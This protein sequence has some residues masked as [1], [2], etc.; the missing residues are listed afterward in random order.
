MTTNKNLI[1]ILRAAAML[2]I[3]SIQLTQY[4]ALR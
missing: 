2:V 3:I 4:N 1:S